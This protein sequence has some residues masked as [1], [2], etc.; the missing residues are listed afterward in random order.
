MTDEALRICPRC[1]AH[2]MP[3]A[4]TCTDCHISLL[5]K[6]DY[7]KRFEPLEPSDDLVV[8]MS[9][10][11]GWVKRVAKAV[12][13]AGVRTYIEVIG[14]EDG[15]YGH[16]ACSLHVRPEH[17]AAAL[18]TYRAEIGGAAIEEVEEH[19]LN[20]PA[21]GQP[22]KVGLSYCP[23]CGLNLD[24]PQAYDELVDEGDLRDGVA[25]RAVDPEIQVIAR[26]ARAGR[27]LLVCMSVVIVS[28][29]IM[30]GFALPLYRWPAALLAAT[31]LYALWWQRIFRRS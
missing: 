16:Y 21:C 23:E 1:E 8:V 26:Q 30:I 27:W 25:E 22:R 2:F 18:K 10:E 24:K 5:D 14:P 3:H 9:G 11:P 29:A 7:E 31:G 6:A 17:A 19:I 15:G 13:R 4:Q 12:S 28:L 20:C